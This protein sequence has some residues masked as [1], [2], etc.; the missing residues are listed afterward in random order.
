MFPRQFGLHNVF[1]SQVDRTKTAQNFQD[2]TMREEE[3]SRLFRRKPGTESRIPKIP[4]RLRGE[5]RR[6]VEKLQILH[7]RCSYLELLDYYC[8]IGLDCVR[9][10]GNRYS[11]QLLP[12]RQRAMQGLQRRKR[13]KPPPSSRPL[14]GSQKRMSTVHAVQHLPTCDHG[15]ITKLATPVSSVSAFCRA[16]LQRIIP[17]GFLVNGEG[18]N[19]NLIVLDRKVD[20]FLRLRRFET[21][22]LH[23]L[24]QDFKVL[25]PTSTLFLT[26]H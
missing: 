23:E 24:V 22:S 21:A 7:G 15:C 5:A 2:Y 17:H 16:T 10:P 8:P 12:N 9:S 1:T 13:N 6:L 19:H 4:K 26:D 18:H 3:I 11:T 20:H 25:V 14:F